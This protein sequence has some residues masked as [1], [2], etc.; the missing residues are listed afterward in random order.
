M[1]LLTGCV[2]P[3]DLRIFKSDELKVVN[4]NITGCK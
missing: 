1:L 2:I 3:A 4:E